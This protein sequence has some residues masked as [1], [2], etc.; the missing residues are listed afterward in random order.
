MYVFSQ[1]CSSLHSDNFFAPPKL[2]GTIII[3]ET[4]IAPGPVPCFCWSQFLPLFSE[5]AVG[6]PHLES[7]GRLWSTSPRRQGLHLAAPWPLINSKNPI[8]LC[9]EYRHIPSKPIGWLQTNVSRGNTELQ[10]V[11]NPFVWLHLG[12]LPRMGQQHSIS[13]EC[14][15]PTA[16]PLW[17]TSSFGAF[18]L[19]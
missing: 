5:A 16:S 9:N 10:M 1:E 12:G 2:S 18:T 19:N 11:C 13:S 15:S 4:L 8:H 17:N 14:V 6:A 3:P 7:T